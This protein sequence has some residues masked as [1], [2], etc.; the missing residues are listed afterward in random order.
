MY[1]PAVFGKMPAQCD[2]VTEVQGF[3]FGV[4]LRP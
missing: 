4:E 3:R 1:S 2:V